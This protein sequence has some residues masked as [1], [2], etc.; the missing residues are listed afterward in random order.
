[1]KQK[2]IPIL[3]ILEFIY[4]IAGFTLVDVLLNLLQGEPV[5][6]LSSL[7]FSA[8]FTLVFFVLMFIWLV[9]TGKFRK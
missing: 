9:F 8:F 1:M 6:I 4:Y 3:K 7:A 5:S 2:P